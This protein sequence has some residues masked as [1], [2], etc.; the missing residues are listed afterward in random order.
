MRI[1]IT[2]LL[3]AGCTQPTPT[4]TGA[5]CPDVDNPQYTWSNFG[6]DFMCHYCTNCHDSSL[7]L[8]DRNGAP[9]FHDLDSLVGVMDVKLHTDE[10]AAWGP[11]AH[12]N[13]MPGGG[14][15][16]R[17]PSQLGGPL[18]MACMEPTDTEREQLG[19]FLACEIQRTQDWSGP[20]GAV[21]DHC[22]AWMMAHPQ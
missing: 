1:I 5:T 16:G 12:N 4:Q 18:D 6:Y 21:T 8:N 2:M 10:Q 19:T 13:F 17:C 22:A 3:V 14:T 15:N 11:K 7:G 9:L 20:E